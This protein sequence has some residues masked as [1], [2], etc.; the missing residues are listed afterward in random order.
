MG[1]NF[2]SLPALLCE[3]TVTA[4]AHIALSCDRNDVK[5]QSM[6]ADRFYGGRQGRWGSGT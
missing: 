1:T 3:L 2:E 5:E 4:I 6:F